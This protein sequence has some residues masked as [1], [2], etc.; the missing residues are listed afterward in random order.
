M[1]AGKALE[2]A[3]QAEDADGGAVTLKVKEGTLP[4][5][6]AFVPA[7]GKFTWTPKEEQTGKH[8]VVFMAADNYETTEKSVEITVKSS[9]FETVMVEAS[10][11][12]TVKSYQAEK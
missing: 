2:F 12:A 4:T 11:D 9:K 8:T 5:G 6:A 3:V 10:E 1:E 7:N